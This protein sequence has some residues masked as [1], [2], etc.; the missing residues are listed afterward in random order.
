MGNARP[1]R[2]R[3]SGVAAKSWLVAATRRVLSG[4]CG[5]WDMF[6]GDLDSGRSDI[7]F[8]G[9][10]SRIRSIFASSAAYTLLTCAA[11]SLHAG[12]G[13]FKLC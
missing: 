8:H 11:V 13:A 4:A 5:W 6:V 7:V 3:T 12:S 9:L 2:G 1:L 10:K